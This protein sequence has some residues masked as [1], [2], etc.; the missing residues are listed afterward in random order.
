MVKE[1]PIILQMKLEVAL[2]KRKIMTCTLFRG[3]KA[4]VL[5]ILIQNLESDVKL[6]TEYLFRSGDESH[7]MF[8]I[9]NGQVNLLMVNLKPADKWRKLYEGLMKENEESSSLHQIVVDKQQRDPWSTSILIAEKQ[10]EVQ[11]D[12]VKKFGYF[13]E[14]ALIGMPQ[15]VSARTK[16]YCELLILDCDPKKTVGNN[17]NPLASVATDYPQFF[18]KIQKAINA[19][20]KLWEESMHQL[21]GKPEKESGRDQ[22]VENIKMTN[23]DSS[24]DNEPTGDGLEMNDFQNSEKDHKEDIDSD[25]SDSEMSTGS[26]NS[27]DRHGNASDWF[28]R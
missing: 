13:G 12:V 10:D 22:E 14:Q 17:K 23:S 21:S 7:Q 28:N 2:K 15:L 5:L 1:L 6:P 19:R 24:V 8:M 26:E 25:A 16:N 11:V 4:E 9:E 20:A 3:V 27:D 18:R